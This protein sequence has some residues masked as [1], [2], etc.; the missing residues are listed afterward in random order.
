MNK[1]IVHDALILFAFTIVL[2]LYLSCV[3]CHKTFN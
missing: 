1:K 2:G 3:R